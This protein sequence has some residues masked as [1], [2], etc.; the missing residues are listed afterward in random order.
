MTLP[1]ISQPP[2]LAYEHNGQRIA[3]DAFY[4]IACDPRRSVAVEACAGAGKTWMLVSRIVRALLD[5][6]PAHEILA[7]TFTKKAAGEMRE[8]LH[9]WLAEF[10]RMPLDA[11]GEELRLRGIVEEIDPQRRQ[12]K[13][14]ALQNL[15]RNLLRAGRP[16]Q[17]RTFHG[18]FAALLRTA[19]LA[20]LQ[21]LGFPTGYELLE[22]D[23]E[24]V[25]RV[26][27][28]FWGALLADGAARADFE[29]LVA[30]H[31]RVQAHKALEAALARRTEFALA[32]AQGVADASVQ[33]FA[34]LY[35]ALAGVDEPWQ[36]L[37]GDAARARW[38]GWSAALGR[39]SAKT[40]QKAAA[41]IADALLLPAGPGQLAALR[42][43]IFVAAQ[44]R[45]TAHLQK[46]AAA[47]EA[48]A[49][50]Q[51]LCAAQ[52]QHE[53]WVYHQRLVRLSRLL[54]AE[55]AALKRERGW[56]DMND[57]ERAALVLLSDGVLSGWVQEKLDARVRQL[58]VDEFQDT[59]PLQW[60]ALH[61]WL[62][63]YAGA[64]RAP[65]VFIVGDPKQSIYRFRRAEP[66]VFR[67]AQVFVVE[68]LGG[69]RLACDHT[70]RNAPVVIAAVNAALQVAQD[71]GEYAGFR[72]HT[73]ESR[74]Q[75]AVSC[76]PQ[77][78]REAEDGRP[79]GEPAG[80][81]DS[82]ATPRLA[83]EETLRAREC[84]QAARWLAARVAAGTL[85]AQD[86][87]VL[88]R[89]RAHLAVMQDE[90]RR[91]GL[92]TEQPEK[93][94]LADAPEVQ[95]VVALL[96]ALVSPG[97]DLS[98]ARALRSPLFGLGDEALARIAL[99]RKQ[100]APE[101]HGWLELL[102]NQELLPPDLRALGPVLTQYRDWLAALPPHDALD[103]I[104]HA[105]DVLARFAAATP[106]PRR[107]AAQ[108]N[109]RALLGAALQIDGARYATPYAFVRA[110]KAGAAQAPVQTG[111][112]H[113]VGEGAVRLLTVHG[114]KG[115]EAPLVL[116]LDTDAAPPRA[117]TMGVL[118]DW[119][120][121]LPAPRRFAFIASE[122]QPPACCEAL[123]AA[124]QAERRREEINALYVALTRARG[125]VVVSS[126]QPH[127]SGAAPSWWQRLQPLCA[128]AEAEA[129]D[130]PRQA[131]DAD[132]PCLLRTLPEL[133]PEMKLA[134][135]PPRAAPD[136]ADPAAA[137]LGEAMHRLLE[138][139]RADAPPPWA[140]GS[141][142]LQAVAREFGLDPLQAAEAAALARR[143]HEGEGAWAWQAALLDWHGN[144]VELHHQGALL[145]LDRLVRRRD[146][147]EWWVLD[148]K[149]AAAPERQP[150]LLEQ[151]AQYR[152]AVAALNPGA[153]VRAAFLTGQG[154]VVAVQGDG[155][156]QAESMPC[157]PPIAGPAQP[158][159]FPHAP[160]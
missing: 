62:S 66:Q 31:G 132:A 126:V 51:T 98:L 21:Q 45:L 69:D 92:P 8:R 121:E 35:P 16:V 148:Y 55:F 15:Q 54:L 28:R 68:G 84:R 155:G 52:R 49:E 40:P 131:A 143:I 116:L 154:T 72:T 77:I 105:G 138:E 117:E 114:A 123:L 82:L 119:P 140:D 29:A 6:C 104:F 70:R 1:P 41:A 146:T 91:L 13:R 33:P 108:A 129:A 142:Q 57:V 37:Q 39:E 7:I 71:A 107:E 22:D 137:R 24:A 103:A 75:G 76:L 150:A 157:A 10:S 109:L 118:V 99:A 14:Q 147:G 73:T 96:D 79:P 17:I 25:E 80:W 136:A 32:D 134:A 145:R 101:C 20:V 46:F 11:L 9:A 102:L 38:H 87:M 81:R 127:R 27:R 43:A 83:P 159:L 141:P 58:L 65:A 34:A 48:E 26:W 53:A 112:G 133:P 153:V 156:A 95:D 144:E 5:G 47:Q 160:P 97:H 74:A 111:G 152:R 61:A 130:P 158:D 36:A 100:A 151:L 30:S 89:R 122:S 44:D 94:S 18:W 63:G 149:T 88:S 125:E 4:A 93:T 78:V 139:L 135:Q 50:L 86:V 12:D 124:E 19:P 64:A 60:Q 56:V 59:N 42:K 110:L 2:A 23:A 128:L 3:R 90:L 113:G 106:A 67:A 115:L 85:R 120:G